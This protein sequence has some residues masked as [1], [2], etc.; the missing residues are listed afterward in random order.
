MSEAADSA[1]ADI[2]P[3]NF[4]NNDVNNH[5]QTDDV[6]Q[7]QHDD[8][9]V[10]TT[11]ADIHVKGDDD[12]LNTSD[13]I[14]SDLPA[15][16]LMSSPRLKPSY[17]KIDVGDVSGVTDSRVSGRLPWNGVRGQ[18]AVKRAALQQQKTRSQVCISERLLAFSVCHFENK[19]NHFFIVLRVAASD[20]V[21]RWKYGTRSQ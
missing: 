5:Q 8:V 3:D 15:T 10:F 11:I 9:T 7:Q 14:I 18:A 12:K 1:A 21:S 17:V 20:R 6:I 4:T 16:E 2:G 13:V 19:K